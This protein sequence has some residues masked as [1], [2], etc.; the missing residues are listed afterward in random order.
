MTF[1]R[2]PGVRRLSMD[3][4]EGAPPEPAPAAAAPSEP[5]PTP[6]PAWRQHLERNAL[7][8]SLGAL[9][10]AGA[11]VAVGIQVAPETFYDR[12]WWEDIY[13]PLVVDARQCRTAATCP[14]LDGPTGVVVKD[15]Y[16]V[17]SELTYGVVLATLLYGIYVGIFRRFRI[18]ADGWFVLG[19]MPWIMI[20]PLARALEDANLFCKPGTDCDPG[21]FAYLFISPVIYVH[22]ALYVIPALLL[23]V[24]I[25][26]HRHEDPRKLTGIVGGVLALGVA[27]YALIGFNYASGFSALAPLWAIALAAL[28]AGALFHWRARQGLASVNLTTFTLGLP[29]ALGCLYLIAKWLSGDIWSRA[30]WN[31]NLFYLAGAFIIAMAALSAALVYAASRALGRGAFAATWAR[32]GG[33]VSERTQNAFG[34]WGA[35]AFIAGLLLAGILPA[36]APVVQ[37]IPSREILIPLLTLGGVGALLAFAFSHVGRELGRH[38]SA[39]LVFALGMNVAL[40]FAHMMDGLATWVAL[41]DPIGFGIPQYSE[42]HPFSEFLLH[43]WNGFM[44]PFVKLVMVLVV[45]WMLDRETRTSAD[46]L[47]ARNMVGLV[48]MAI[49]VLGF[50]PGLRDVL[51]LTMGV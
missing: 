4:H 13:G 26:E 11:V 47:D 27:A 36:L 20:G 24:W 45:A 15:G 44:F 22:I 6:L 18:V 41:E 35:I 37:D 7:W 42:K 14:G 5:S 51:R 49:F 40:V 8:W 29:F 2:D 33:K 16:T 9:A 30:A 21:V 34:K 19:L 32:A 43:Y 50:A 46:T 38:P 3:E 25:R 31:G 23:G 48:K 28:L 39:L 1:T 17:T 10:L 12:F